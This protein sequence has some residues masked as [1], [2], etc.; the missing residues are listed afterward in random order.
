MAED[1]EIVTR[2][3]AEAA[4]LSHTSEKGWL[5]LCG[6]DRVVSALNRYLAWSE[7][8]VSGEAGYAS[9]TRRLT[10]AVVR[11]STQENFVTWSI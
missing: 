11:P 3:S 6:A 8:V 4:H 1:Q 10:L 5:T 7:T 2:Y 9:A